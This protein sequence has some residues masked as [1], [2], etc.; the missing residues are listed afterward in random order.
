V[1]QDQNVSC[2]VKRYRQVGQDIDAKKKASGQYA[3]GHIV[4]E[5]EGKKYLVKWSN[6]SQDADEMVA[7]E[8]IRVPQF[9]VRRSRNALSVTRV[10][11]QVAGMTD[12]E[13]HVLW[14]ADCDVTKQS[15]T[16]SRLR[17]SA[18]GDPDPAVQDENWSDSSAG[19]RV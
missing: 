11:E 12:H 5:L 19:T 4:R 17:K 15:D 2:F 10:I 1:R 9:Q 16:R 7:E 14:L 18:L 6:F 3:P 13:E 8:D